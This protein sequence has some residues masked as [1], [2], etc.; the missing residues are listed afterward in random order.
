MAVECGTWGV[1]DDL[2][3]PVGDGGEPWTGQWGE[4]GEAEEGDRRA[5]GLFQEVWVRRETERIYFSWSYFF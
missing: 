3:E 2:K 4:G 1:I 5:G